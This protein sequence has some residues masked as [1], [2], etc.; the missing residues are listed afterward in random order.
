[1]KKHFNHFLL[2]NQ[3][4]FNIIYFEKYFMKLYSLQH[5]QIL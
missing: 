5:F 4:L 1:M 3:N 2:K